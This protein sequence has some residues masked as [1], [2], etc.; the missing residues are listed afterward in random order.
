[1]GRGKYEDI[2]KAIREMMQ[3][4]VMRLVIHGQGNSAER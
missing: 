1:M 3:N 4:Y 2:K